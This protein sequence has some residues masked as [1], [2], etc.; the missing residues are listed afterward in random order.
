[1]QQRKVGDYQTEKKVNKK[2]Y[3]DDEDVPISSSCEVWTKP[4][5]AIHRNKAAR[6]RKENNTRRPKRR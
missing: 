3:K 5:K 4:C 6:E 2:K 1:M